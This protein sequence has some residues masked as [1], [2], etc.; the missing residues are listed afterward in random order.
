[1][2]D[3]EIITLGVYNIVVLVG[4]RLLVC[5]PFLLLT[6]AFLGILLKFLHV[7]NSTGD[8]KVV[9][10]AEVVQVEV[11]GGCAHTILWFDTVT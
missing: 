5:I 11:E 6:Q 7:G 2:W 8:P 1:L 4:F 3:G 9:V 10:V